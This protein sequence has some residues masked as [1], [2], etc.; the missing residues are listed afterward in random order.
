MKKRTLHERISYWI[1]CM[2]SKGP[3]AMSILL[4]AVTFAIVIVIGVVAS[5]ASDEG[6]VLYQ[7]WF[8]LM[9]TLDAGNLS[10]V[11]TDNIVYLILMFLAMRSYI[12][13]FWE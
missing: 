13:Y 12:R 8:S 1:D 10:G 7:I 9:Q 5:F 2:M 3:I 4:F 6:S 11:A